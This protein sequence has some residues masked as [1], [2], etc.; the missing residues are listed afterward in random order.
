MTNMISRILFGTLLMATMAH[1]QAPAGDNSPETKPA[2]REASEKNTARS[3]ALY[4]RTKES[5]N[6]TIAAI[7]AKKGSG[8]LAE[9]QE[10][11]NAL[12][13]YRYLCGVPF[14]VKVN[15]SMC[16]QAQSAADACA[17]KGTLSHSLGAYTDQCNLAAASG[18]LPMVDTVHIYMDDAGANNREV[19]GHRQHCLKYGLTSTGF[20]KQKGFGAMRVMLGGGAKMPKMKRGWSYPGNGFYPAAW[21]KGNGWSYYAPAGVSM[22]KANVAMWKLAQPPT[23]APTPSEL[24]QAQKISIG[25]VFKHDGQI[26]FEPGIQTPEGIYWVEI[27]AGN[28]SDKYVV[29]FF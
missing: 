13:V 3:K 12:N 11:V 1:A 8:N 28:F 25:S 24:Q 19:R 6:K 18:N 16:A 4:P 20:G 27:K 21:M 22:K 29:E 9:A 15:A 14:S 5:I 2:R 10:A 7:Q 17:A 23:K 26:V